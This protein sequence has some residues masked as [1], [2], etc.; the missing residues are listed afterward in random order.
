MQRGQSPVQTQTEYIQRTYDTRHETRFTSLASCLAPWQHSA[1]NN[2]TTRPDKTF[3]TGNKINVLIQNK[4]FKITLNGV[5]STIIQEQVRLSFGKASRFKTAR[6][7]VLWSTSSP[8][9]SINDAFSLKDPCSVKKN[10][11]LSL[12]HFSSSKTSRLALPN[13]LWYLKQALGGNQRERGGG[14]RNGIGLQFP[15]IKHLSIHTYAEEN[16]EQAQTTTKRSRCQKGKHKK[17]RT[18]GKKTGPAVN[19]WH[20]QLTRACLR[21]H[22]GMRVPSCSH[23]KNNCVPRDGAGES[24]WSRTRASVTQRRSWLSSTRSQLPL[25]L[26][27]MNCNEIKWKLMKALM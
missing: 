1:M 20:H 4:I 7:H 23:E 18:V 3:N 17:T 19:R 15:W 9:Q 13:M 22:L 16:V 2:N 8:G 25:M 5:D 10:F 12:S 27:S 6:L 21:S 24:T 26:S 11:N 14:G